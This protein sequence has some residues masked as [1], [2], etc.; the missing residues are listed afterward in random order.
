MS[1][2]FG[3]LTQFDFVKIIRRRN[4]TA[5]PEEGIASVGLLGGESGLFTPTISNIT[6]DATVDVSSSWWYKTSNN[7]AKAVFLLDVTMG[8]GQNGTFFNVSTPI[9]SQFTNARQA[10]GQCNVVENLVSFFVTS[11]DTDLFA[12]SVTSQNNQDSIQGISVSVE[13]LIV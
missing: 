8:S 4:E 13:F 6:N 12:F 1:I 11:F 9:A 3:N 2:I 10:T 7:T 5:T